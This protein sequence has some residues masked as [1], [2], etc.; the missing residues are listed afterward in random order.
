MARPT[1]QAA[2]RARPV[3][4]DGV[5]AGGLVGGALVAP[6]LPGAIGE[7]LAALMA[8]GTVIAV[9]VGALALLM[10]LLALFYQP[11]MS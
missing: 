1:T 2:G 3:N 6:V 10:V 11:T 7:E 5:P 8:G 9:G 4:R